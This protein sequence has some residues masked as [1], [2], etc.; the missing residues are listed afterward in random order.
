VIDDPDR[1]IDAVLGVDGADDVEVRVSRH[2]GG[3]T[4][5][6]N[7]TVHQHVQTD[8]THLSVRV[9]VGQ[10]VGATTT[11]DVTPEGAARA[12][13][14]ALAAARVTPPDPHYPGMAGPSP[15]PETAPRSDPGT[16]VATP[17]ARVALVAELVAQLRDGQTAAGALETTLHEVLHATSAG[18]RHEGRS[19]RAALSTVVTGGGATGHAEDASVRIDEL[20]PADVGERAAATCAAAVGP[21][22]HEP[23]EFDVVLLPSAVMTMLEYLSFTTFSAKAVQEGRSCFAERMGHLVASP[24]V[25]IA[26][27]A[28]RPDAIGLAFDGEA[29]PKRRV[30]LIVEGVAT[31]VVHDRATAKVAGVESTGHGLPAPNPWGP[32]AGSLVLA[33]G[34][35][36][37]DDLVAGIDT[38]LLVTRFWYA[39]TVNAKKTT[40]TGMTRDGT[41]RIVDGAVGPSVC[42][43]RF[44]QSILGALAACDGVGDMLRTCSDESSDTRC[45]AIRVRGFAFTSSSDH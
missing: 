22:D 40:I 10:R 33:P 7:S 14:A 6:A 43:L 39:R 1:L 20:D 29:T 36:T 9:A 28:L 44:N 31:G 26:D 11:N 42:N 12:A 3:L 45:P 37:L 30:E 15:L 13:Q 2:A 25:S 19:T 18:A 32:F 38:G 4:R 27:D 41:F 24:L 17:A 16:A 35:S 34:P 21:G 23:G 8:T 5:F